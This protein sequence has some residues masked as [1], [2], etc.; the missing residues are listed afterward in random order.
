MILVV[1][2]VC[3]AYEVIKVYLYKF[4]YCT[5]SVR[6]NTMT[7]DAKKA[8]I[9]SAIKTWLRVSSDRGGGRKKRAEAKTNAEAF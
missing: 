3:V 5:D 9:E 1:Y 8:E 2:V 7:K 6:A 4:V